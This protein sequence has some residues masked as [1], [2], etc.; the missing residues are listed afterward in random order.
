MVE[1]FTEIQ[2]IIIGSI[3]IICFSFWV[4]LNSYLILFFCRKGFKFLGNKGFKIYS[5]ATIAINIAIPVL[6]TITGL[7]ALFT[8]QP[9]HVW[10][11]F[12]VPS[13]TGMLIG[14]CFF[15][16]IRTIFAKHE[17]RKMQAKDL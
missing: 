16:F 3:V 1:W 8:K 2:A 15:P 6:L 5:V 9:H 13:Y 11:A 14:A 4:A 10:L 12:L 17:I 7:I